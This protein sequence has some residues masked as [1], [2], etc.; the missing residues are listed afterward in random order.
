M[1]VAAP[2][3]GANDER[4]GSDLFRPSFGNLLPVI[5]NDNM[6]SNGHHGAHDMLNDYDGQSAVAKLAHER[7]GL[8]DLRGIQTSHNLVQKKKPGSGCQRAGEFEPPLID[9]I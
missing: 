8:I 5:E 4:V 6:L 7:D 3:I 9:R 1:S 2:E